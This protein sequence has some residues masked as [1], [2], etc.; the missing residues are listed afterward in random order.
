[1]PAGWQPIRE[2]PIKNDRGGAGME[3]P[4]QVAVTYV[5]LATKTH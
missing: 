2:E 1:M 3:S 4:A 5:W